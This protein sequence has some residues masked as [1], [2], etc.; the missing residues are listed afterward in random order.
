[1][2]YS[3]LMAGRASVAGKVEPM[4]TTVIEHCPTRVSHEVKGF[5]ARYLDFCADHLP[6][7]ETC[8]AEHDLASVSRI[9]HALR[10]NAGFI[11]LSELSS[12]S[13]QLEQ[14]CVGSD[15]AAIDA[16]Y[17]AIAE[18]VH[19]LRANGGLSIH[20]E[21]NPAPLEQAVPIKRTS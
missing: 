17:R 1:M 13:G 8:I 12:L 15:W 5:A 21:R 10:G 19:K 4:R 2:L 6:Q 20:V 9:A 7:L 3:R 16:A 11:G 18:T 14:Y